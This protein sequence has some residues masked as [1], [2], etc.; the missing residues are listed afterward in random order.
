MDVPLSD[1]L[2]LSL[3][4][5]YVGSFLYDDLTKRFKEDRRRLLA[6]RAL[7]NE[8]ADDSSTSSEE[9]PDDSDNDSDDSQSASDLEPD[10]EDEGMAKNIRIKSKPSGDDSESDST[11]DRDKPSSTEKRAG[12]DGGN[13]Q[14]N[15]GGT[16]KSITH[17]QESTRS[18]ALELLNMDVGYSSDEGGDEDNAFYV[19]S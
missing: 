13:E 19:S 11:G 8:A 1:S 15:L 7:T 4:F 17:R 18:L 9:P 6:K 5:S 3:T 2:T 10:S 12:G 16:E 14:K